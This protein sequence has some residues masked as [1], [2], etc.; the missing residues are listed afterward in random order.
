MTN[1]LTDLYYQ[2]KKTKT[3]LISNDQKMLRAPPRKFNV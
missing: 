2:M 3:Y 1:G